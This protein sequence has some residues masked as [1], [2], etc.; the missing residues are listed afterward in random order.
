MAKKFLIKN[1]R[2]EVKK[3]LAGDFLSSSDKKSLLGD[4]KSQYEKIFFSDSI[5]SFEED[6][7]E[8]II[9]IIED[10]IKGISSEEEIPYGEYL[11]RGV[12]ILSESSAD[13]NIS[14]DVWRKLREYRR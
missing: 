4:L 9:G 13:K 5:T 2:I 1:V 7:L 14:A 11:E 3:I 6:K 8:K 10:A 12:R